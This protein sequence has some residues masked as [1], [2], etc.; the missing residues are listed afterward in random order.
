VIERLNF[1]DLYG[2]LLPGAAAVGVGVL[3]LLLT[4]SSVPSLEWSSALAT[5]VLAYILGHLL[6]I[7]ARDGFGRQV[8]PSDE[9]ITLEESKGGFPDQFK[10][11]LHALLQKDFDFDVTNA[12]QRAQAFNACRYAAQSTDYPSYAEQYQGLYALMR[13]LA[14]AAILGAAYHVGWLAGALQERNPVFAS[15]MATGGFLAVSVAGTIT[16]P[17]MVAAA[18]ALV[19]GLFV[20]E[21]VRPTSELV[22]L[23]SAGVVLT[24]ASRLFLRSHRFFQRHFAATVYSVYYARRRSP[25]THPEDSPSGPKK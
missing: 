2:Y 4:G 17:M 23:A 9:L 5:L 12:A 25:L 22:R 11:Q 1:Y 16:T 3:P 21:S 20:D 18:A 19:S 15:A 24:V 13:G 6:Q 7:V 8:H 14:A 10:Q